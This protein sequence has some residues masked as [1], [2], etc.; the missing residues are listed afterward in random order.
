MG[1]NEE[2][3]REIWRLRR[4]LYCSMIHIKLKPVRVSHE[5][6]CGECTKCLAAKGDWREY[7][8][9]A[10][11]YGWEDYESSNVV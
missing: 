7:N 5:A 4:M 2:L 3:K 6:A 8:R 1:S 9:M 10:K 11:E